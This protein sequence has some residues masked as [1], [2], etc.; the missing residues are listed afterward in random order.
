MTCI[1][2]FKSTIK[3]IT[4][5]RLRYK[6][7]IAVLI[8]A[9]LLSSVM[10]YSAYKAAIKKEEKNASSKISEGLGISFNNSIEVINKVREGLSNHSETITIRYSAKKDHVEDI[11][12]LCANLIDAALED[13]SDATLGDY[14][15]Y[16]YGGYDADYGYSEDGDTLHYVI[17]ITPKYYTT[18]EQEEV[19]TKDINKILTSFNFSVLTSDYDKVE[20]IYDYI[21]A[22]VKFDQVHKNNSNSHL[23]T[24]AYSALEY[25]RAVCQGFSVLMYRMLKQSG[26]ECRVVTGYADNGKG[27]KE[28]HAW[29]IIRLDGVWYN[30][31]ATW[32]TEGE[33][34]YFLKSDSDFTDHDRLEEFKGEFYE[35]YPMSQK[36]Y[37]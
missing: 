31:D 1:T 15:R 23:K 2:K 26:V 5:V 37:I 14:I 25:K 12:M 3:C 20:T 33:H 29:N 35:D 22:N 10:I 36:S 13:T 17:T 21:C 28:Y 18:I 8:A 32:D 6:L 34:K 24:T 9:I 11:E 19:V 16:Q 7:L 30:A 4:A 27:E